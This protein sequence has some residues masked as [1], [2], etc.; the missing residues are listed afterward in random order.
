MLGWWWGIPFCRGPT[1]HPDR[2]CLEAVDKHAR[3]ADE[4]RDRVR[5]GLREVAE[6]LVM[7]HPGCDICAKARDE[8]NRDGQE[9]WGGAG[10][11]GQ[12]QGEVTGQACRPSVSC[13]LSGPRGR[14]G[15]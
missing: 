4:D 14:E 8:M 15:N 2:V 11:K 6:F 5:R 1:L 10:Q 7:R 9:G 13:G 3:I 12:I